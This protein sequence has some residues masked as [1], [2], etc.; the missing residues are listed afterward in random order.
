[1]AIGITGLDEMD[2]ALLGCGPDGCDEDG[3]YVLGKY[4]HD[5]H[6]TNRNNKLHI[7][8]ITRTAG[9][10]RHIERIDYKDEIDAKICVEIIDRSENTTAKYLGVR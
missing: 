7:V 10:S 6:V 4:S 3:V 8:E 1:M 5:D 9:A 2:Q